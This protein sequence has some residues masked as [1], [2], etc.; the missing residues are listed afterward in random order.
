MEDVAGERDLDIVRRRIEIGELDRGPE[1]RD[2]RDRRGAVGA[3]G[4]ILAHVHGDLRLGDRLA[5]SLRPTPC[6]RSAA[7][8]SAS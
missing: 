2:R 8:T 3:A 1:R 4:Q 7:A 5:S 6:R